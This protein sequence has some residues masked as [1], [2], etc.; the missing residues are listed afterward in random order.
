MW[1]TISINETVILPLKQAIGIDEFKDTVNPNRSWE[2]ISMF[3]NTLLTQL[4]N[5]NNVE[6]SAKNTLIMKCSNQ[7]HEAIVRQLKM[8]KFFIEDVG[9]SGVS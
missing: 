8:S 2:G 6:H 3:F 7:I 1:Q 9:E 4:K 5:R